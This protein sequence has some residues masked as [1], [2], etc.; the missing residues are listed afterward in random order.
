MNGFFA[1]HSSVTRNVALRPCG[2]QGTQ[3]VGE[4]KNNAEK[5]NLKDWKPLAICI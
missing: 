4:N 1:D 3:V 2:S 5:K